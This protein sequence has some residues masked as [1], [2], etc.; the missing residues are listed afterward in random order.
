MSP[1]FFF[2]VSTVEIITKRWT[3]ASD[4]YKRQKSMKAKSGRGK[5]KNKPYLYTKYLRFLDAVMDVGD[6]ADNLAE[7]PAPEMAA[8][9]GDDPPTDEEDAGGEA[10]T[11]T[12]EQHGDPAPATCPP[13]RLSATPMHSRWRG[14]PQ[15]QE[16][17]TMENVALLE[18]FDQLRNRR[19]DSPEDLYLRGLAPELKKVAE[20]DMANCKAAL[21][22]VVQIFKK[23]DYLYK[24]EVALFLDRHRERVGGQLPPSPPRSTRLYPT[25]EGP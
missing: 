7:P 17:T 25:F 4:Q 5:L 21:L 10:G 15:A 13:A 6:T 23:N 11:S 20:Q 2:L 24:N 1:S 8:S 12:Q 18:I 9:S 3:S 19:D 22:A 14:P 16:K